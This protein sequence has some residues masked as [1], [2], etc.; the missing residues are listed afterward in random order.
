MNYQLKSEHFNYQENDTSGMANLYITMCRLVPFIEEEDRDFFNS[1]VLP[2]FSKLYKK[3]SLANNQLYYTKNFCSNNVS[4]VIDIRTNL[5]FDAKLNLKH[6]GDLYI[7]PVD[8]VLENISLSEI[9]FSTWLDKKIADKSFQNFKI[10]LN[11]EYKEKYYQATFSFNAT[12]NY[13]IK[14]IITT[15]TNV[16]NLDI[17]VD[18][19]NLDKMVAD[20]RLSFTSCTTQQAET[21]IYYLSLLNILDENKAISDNRKAPFFV[22]DFIDS[23]PE[24]IHELNAQLKKLFKSDLEKM[25]K[26]M[27]ETSKHNLYP[28]KV[29]LLSVY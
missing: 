18:F 17:I 14:A 23:L 22:E 2:I 21:I 8:L 4:F 6:I 13:I 28:K 9:K 16:Q 26:I 3:E 11:K 12:N 19:S 25:K 20:E 29:N 15:D 24:T 7:K 27:R 1:K 5:G 10:G